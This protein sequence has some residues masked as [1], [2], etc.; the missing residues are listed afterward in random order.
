M[1]IYSAHVSCQDVSRKTFS[2]QHMV[3][4]IMFEKCSSV[5]R[6][7][8]AHIAYCARFRRSCCTIAIVLHFGLDVLFAQYTMY[9]IAHVSGGGIVRSILFW[10]FFRFMYCTGNI[11]TCI[12]LMFLVEVLYCQCKISLVLGQCMVRPTLQRTCFGWWYCTV[13]VVSNIDPSEVWKAEQHLL[14]TSTHRHWLLYM[15]S[16]NTVV[17]YLQHELITLTTWGP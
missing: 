3:G 7:G 4:F 5:C 13:D 8:N 11:N 6:L 12:L 10:T 15:I 14:H 16:F 17:E 9:D 1:S 2:G